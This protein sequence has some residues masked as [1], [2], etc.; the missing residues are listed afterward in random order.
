LPVRLLWT[1][2]NKNT[3]SHLLGEIGSY[4]GLFWAWEAAVIS[5]PYRT[6][7]FLGSSF[8]ARD[9][10]V[11][12]KDPMDN[13]GQTALDLINRAATAAR[14]GNSQAISTINELTLQLQTASNRIK[15]LEAKAEHYQARAERA[16]RWFTAISTEIQRQFLDLGNKQPD[17]PPRY[18]H[19]RVATSEI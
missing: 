13:A 7:S 18:S 5:K 9:N 10:L 12:L 2:S 8:A 6:D 1:T 11:E 15:E 17:Q 16:E 3:Q 19:F 4:A 14:E